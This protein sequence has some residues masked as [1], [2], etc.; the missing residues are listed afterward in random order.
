MK[1]ILFKE[2]MKIQESISAFFP[3]YNDEITIEKII[4]QTRKILKEITNDFEIIIIDDCSPDNCG[5]IGDQLSKKYKEVKVIHHKKNKGYG[6][7]LKSG[8]K[9]ATKDLVFYTDGDAQYNVNEL[10]ILIN[11]MV[12]GIDVVNG[13]KL[14]RADNLS[15]CVL[16]SLY[17]YFVRFMFNLK[18]KDVDC[19]FRLVRRNI[20]DKVKLRS[21]TGIICLEMMKKIQ[22]AGFTITN[23]PVHHYPRVYGKSAFFNI[24]N[25]IKVLIRIVYLWIELVLFKKYR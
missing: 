4:E 7:V 8:F 1:D 9:T 11:Y 19:D 13:Y 21:N 20:F 22:N 15:R 14:Y 2:I 25:I 23:V 18:V 10:K 17:N 6:G 12:K 16:G 24:L 3:A 5:K